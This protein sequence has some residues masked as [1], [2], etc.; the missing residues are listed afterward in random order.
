M[1][2]TSIKHRIRPSSE[3]MAPLGGAAGRWCAEGFDGWCCRVT[4]S[5]GSYRLSCSYNIAIN[6]LVA[7]T[8]YGVVRGLCQL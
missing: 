7:T 2:W 4:L 1:L 5:L 8:V 6:I 3:V